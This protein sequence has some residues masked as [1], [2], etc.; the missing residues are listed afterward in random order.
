MIKYQ[1][2]QGVRLAGAPA[3][4][5]VTPTPEGKAMASIPGWVVFIDP[6]YRVDSGVRN[7]ASASAVFPAPDDPVGS[8]SFP[9][10]GE[11][12]FAIGEGRERF[13][14][15]IAFPSEAWT[16]FAVLNGDFSAG[17]SK[18]I[19]RSVNLDEEYALRVGFNSSGSSMAVYTG[20]T[21]SVYR[22]QYEPPVSFEGR[23]A[24]AMY[25]FSTRDGLRLYHNG[26]LGAHEP[27]ETQPLTHSIGP[28][29]WEFFS[30]PLRGLVG[31]TGVLSID[32]GWPEHAGYRRSIEQFLMS[33]YGIV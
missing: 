22:I 30:I 17:S 18:E 26:Q 6:D 12:A 27:A 20:P 2:L 24:L 10:T 7:R 5:T 14:P 28:N 15:D 25:T 1:V 9:L 13:I 29:Q 4:P 31:M 16:V 19:A 23:T 32:L 3:L 33:K 11:K 8:G 21:P